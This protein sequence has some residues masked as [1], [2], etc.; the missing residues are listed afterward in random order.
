MAARDTET[1]TNSRGAH[2]RLRHLRGAAARVARAFGFFGYQGPRGGAIAEALD[3]CG[4]LLSGAQKIRERAPSEPGT[5]SLE[6]SGSGRQHLRGQIPELAVELD[7]TPD[8]ANRTRAGQTTAGRASAPAPTE[9]VLLAA[10]VDS[11]KVIAHI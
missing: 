5:L 4:P 6:F 10:V 9:Q 8:G 1:P 7:V 3:I 11:P 2:S